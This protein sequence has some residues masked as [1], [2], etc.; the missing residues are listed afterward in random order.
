VD[1][2]RYAGTRKVTTI[3]D[4]LYDG[5]SVYL[6]RKRALYDRLTR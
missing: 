6:D 2:V 1:E 5:A 3:L 4:H